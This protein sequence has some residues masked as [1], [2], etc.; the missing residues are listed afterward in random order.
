M[1]IHKLMGVAAAVVLGGSTV[2]AQEVNQWRGGETAEDWNDKYKWKQNH[3][4]TENESAHFREPISVINVNSTIQL[5]HGMHLYGQEL[6]LQGNG[7]INLW[8]QVPHQRTVNIPASGDGFASLTLND[9]ISLNGRLAL[10]A[11]GFGTSASK[12]SVT[13][14]DRSNVTGELC[15]GNAGTGTG[16]VFIKGNSTYRITG[17]ELGTE[18]KSGGSAE[19]HI[20]SGTVRVETKQD[21]FQTFNAD[22][23][24]K[25][26][27]GEN[28]TLRFEYSMPVAHKKEAIK[29]MI[30]NNRL[31]AAPGC[32][33]TPPIIQEKLVIVRAEDERNDSA[34]KTKEQLLAAID[35]ISAAT[36]VASSGEQPRKLESLLKNMRSGSSSAST[37]AA[38]PAPAP[39]SG[40]NASLAALMQQKGVSN[41][42]PE[43]TGSG[44]GALAGYIAFMGAAIL[45]LRRT[46]AA[47]EVEEEPEPAAP[48]KQA[49]SALKKKNNKKRR[50]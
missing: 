40:G 29:D 25:I 13:L 50:R 5:S 21:P 23:S 42:T 9:N 8:S 11:K 47:P 1:K 45:I 33:L 39:T 36:T 14:K 44:S 34:V 37:P 26:I 48:A 35:R 28:G 4:P 32:R 3:T 27:M 15:I 16:Q 6:S 46:P 24:R 7:N 19:I 43:E 22:A 18:A 2:S 31:V 20:L 12:G 30:K 17:L 49:P 41:E 10:S 38:A